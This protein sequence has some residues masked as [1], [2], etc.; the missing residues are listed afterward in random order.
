MLSI[1]NPSHS[2]P[3]ALLLFGA[4]ILNALTIGSAVIGGLCLFALLF[5]CGTSLGPYVYRG[6]RIA[7]QVV[8][9]ALG[10]ICALLIALT[11]VFYLSPGIPFFAL[12]FGTLIV[13]S[14]IALLPSRG[15]EPALL[16]DALQWLRS[17]SYAFVALCLVTW[18]LRVSSV[19]ITAGVR[20]LWT[21]IDPSLITALGLGAVIVFGLL[22]RKFSVGSASLLALTLFSALSLAASA[23][24]LGYGFDPFIH[25]ATVEHIAAFGSISPKPLYYIGQYVLELVGT[26]VFSLPTLFFDSLL[27]PTMASIMIVACASLMRDKGS[28]LDLCA[29]ALLPLG[30]FISTTPQSLAYTFSACVIFLS[31]R[32]F[33][34]GDIPLWFLWAL[35]ITAVATH[36]IA[37]ILTIVYLA[38]LTAYLALD[39]R[40]RQQSIAALAALGCLSLPAAFLIHSSKPPP[41]V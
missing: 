29:L 18:W 38:I 36:P 5:V 14:V 24:P 31:I 6:D 15:V 37:G 41:S 39:G 13:L 23:Y 28:R 20:S 27:V 30:A 32:M 8:L 17:S 12:S 25:R 1:A 19:D 35:G 11:A 16:V 33:R 34:S 4:A 2:F 40:R 3:T 7:L 26:S 21:V 9:G 22:S 10:T